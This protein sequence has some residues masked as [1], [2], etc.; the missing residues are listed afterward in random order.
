MIQGQ[1]TEGGGRWGEAAEVGGEGFIPAWAVETGSLGRPA[2]PVRVEASRLGPCP[3]FTGFRE[4][5]TVTK[6]RMCLDGSCFQRQN[7]GGEG[8]DRAIPVSTLQVCPAVEIKI[9]HPDFKWD[10]TF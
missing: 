2:R 3:C 5:K 7:V 8:R 4:E 6:Q 1:E 9:N 10:S